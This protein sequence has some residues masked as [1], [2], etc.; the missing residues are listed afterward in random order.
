MAR[1]LMTGRSGFGAAR[2][3]IDNSILTHY[4]DSIVID[5]IVTEMKNSREIQKEQTRALLI[6]TAYDVFCRMGIMRARASDIAQ[7]AHVSHGTVF[8]HFVSMD[9]LIEEVVAVYG[10]RIALRTHELAH[11]R[12]QLAELLRAHLNGIME[13]EPFYAR[14]ILENRLLPPGARDSFIGIQSAISFH[15]SQALEHDASYAAEV[16]PYFL[17]NLW[18]GLVHHYLSNGDLFAPDGGVICRH[19]DMLIKNFLTL[20]EKEGTQYEC[21]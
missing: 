6:R 4:T 12:A 5:W 1:R 7:A 13:F 15:F 3:F 18:V 14:L 17:F 2:F 20:V 8:V 9:A 21:R 11:G 19:G 10:Q 16:P